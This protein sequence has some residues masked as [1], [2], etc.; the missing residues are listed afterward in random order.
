VLNQFISRGGKQ[1]E[2]L[3]KYVPQ[4][5]EDQRYWFVRTN[6]G[7]FYDNFVNEGFIGIGWNQIEIKHLTENRPLSDIVRDKYK[8]ENRP[9][10][11]ANQIKTFCNDM[12]KGDIVLIPSSRSTYIHFGIVRDDEPYEEDIPIEVENIEEHPELLF[13]YEGVCPY[14][15]RRKVDWIKVIRRDDL[16]PQ[17]YKLIYSQHTISNAD[18]YAEYIDKSLFDF[19]VKG[20]KCHFILHVRKKE[21]IKAHHLIPFMSDLLSIAD[22]GKLSSDD[23]IDIKVSVQSPG[24]I[25]LIG[26]IPN[27][28]ILSVIVV[29]IL[30]GRAKFLGMELDTPGIMGRIL[31]W[32]RTKQEEQNQGQET[33]EPTEQQKERLVANAENLDIQLPEQLQK[34]LKAYVEDINKQMSATEETKSKN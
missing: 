12:K 9:N 8:N 14:R 33:N 11:V 31:E 27:I 21:H 23:E 29:A 24:T 15:K 19:Y 30:G 32:R 3:I 6:S 26:Y 18:S 4:I 22:A 20:D 28:I 25:E 16:D 17:L 10:Y 13:E 2:E 34:A 5:P 1:M 7:E